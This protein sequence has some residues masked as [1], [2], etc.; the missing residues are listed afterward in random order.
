MCISLAL[1]QHQEALH[2]SILF[3]LSVVLALPHTPQ[4]NRTQ[5]RQPTAKFT[6]ALP[7]NNTAHV[8]RASGI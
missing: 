1:L 2:L 4:A 3:Q 5:N 6:G 8:S 7:L